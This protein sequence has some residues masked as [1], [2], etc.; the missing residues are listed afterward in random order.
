MEADH[1]YHPPRGCD[2]TGLTPPILSYPHDAGWGNSVT[3]G[4]V[5]RGSA[6]PALQG[7]YLFADFGSGRIWAARRDAGGGWQA[8]RLLD[9]GGAIS[10][11]G[12]TD[13]GELLVADYAAGVLYRLVP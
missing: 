9:T 12:E 5:Y 10:T 1:C 11:F 8:E 2:P 3:G 13:A 4:Y 6:I 7:A